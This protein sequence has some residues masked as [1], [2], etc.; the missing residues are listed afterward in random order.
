MNDYAYFNK[1][2]IEQQKKLLSE[3]NDISD[4][5]KH[6][7]PYRVSLLESN[8]PTKFKAA[9]LKKIN[10]L[11]YMEPGAGEYY[12]SKNCVDTFMHIPFNKYSELPITRTDGI[13]KCHE[14]MENAKQVL[15][16]AVYGLNDAKLQVMQLVGQWITNPSA[17]GTSIAIKGPMGTGK[18]T[19]VK[20][21]ISK[22]LNREFTF[23]ALGGATDS[24]FLEGHS[25][26]YEGS[27]WGRI[28]DILIQSRCMNPIIYFDELDKISDTP[29]GEEIAGILTHLTDTTQNT[30]FHDKY[31][32]EIDFDP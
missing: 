27:T 13:D 18:T 6:N 28:V 10:A 24:S 20:E 26:T 31:F 9:A 8:I 19:L 30:Q 4:Q 23:I 12:K 17:V 16:S 11:R 29:K 21:G 2:S 25:Y 14:F 22:I 7:K 3:L 1:L 5:V 32:S 15:D